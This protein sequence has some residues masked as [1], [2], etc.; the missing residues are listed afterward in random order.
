VQ[1]MLLI[2]RQARHPVSRQ[3]AMHEGGRDRDLMKPREI[4]CDAPRAKMVLPSQVHDLADDLR[5]SRARRG[6]RDS[7]VIGP[8][9]LRVLVEA[10]FPLVE[11]LARCAE[12]PTGARDIAVAGGPTQQPP[13]L[14][15]CRASS[16]NAP[17]S[18]HSGAVRLSN[19]LHLGGCPSGRNAPI[20]I[21]AQN[22]KP[23]DRLRVS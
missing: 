19:L 17:R 13:A 6:M 4:G 10:P 18:A 16:A 2:R 5:R 8:A 12:V 20:T 23:L 3:D 15:A 9:G 22:H 7:G 21:P 14:E 11:R 1:L